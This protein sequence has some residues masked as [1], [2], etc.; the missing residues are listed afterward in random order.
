MSA[1]T[2]VDRAPAP[3]PL[4]VLGS[5][6]SVQVG[7]GLA[8]ILIHQIGASGT[9]L[10]RLGFATVLM[11]LVAR[12]TLR[13]HSRYAIRTVLMFGLIL[14][15]MNFTFYST[16]AHLPIGVAVTIE[17]LGPL[18]LAAVLSRRLLDGVAVAAALVGVLL[19]SQALEVPLAELSWVGLMYALLAAFFWAAYIIYSR[20]VGAAFTQLQ[21]LTIA[22]AVGALVVL[23]LGLDSVGEWTPQR[24]AFGL[25]IAV[26]SSALPYSL[27]LV[28]LRRMSA[29]VFGILMSV[30]P[31]VAALVGLVILGQVLTGYQVLGMALVV[32]ASAMVLGFARSAGSGSERPQTRERGA[33]HPRDPDDS[34]ADEPLLP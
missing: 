5:I 8:T 19:I 14:G 31:A 12:P 28:A 3:A 20:R 4:L 29:R 25:G 18:T 16:L 21:G 10:M 11:L 9:V 24:L 33:P 23:P 27:E 22:M 2:G 15:L 30:E 6:L 1:R 17:F 13:G 34:A 26:L 7:A 32:L